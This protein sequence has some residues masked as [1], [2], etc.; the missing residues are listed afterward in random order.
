MNKNFL[1]MNL[2]K[3]NLLKSYLLKK[4]KYLK[5]MRSQYNMYMYEK[6]RIE[7]ILFSTT[8]FHIKLPLIFPELMMMNMNHISSMNVDIEM[9][10]QCGKWRFKYN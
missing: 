8:Y 2:L 5:I 6:Y 3:R 9:I 7:I 4:I 1:K 10:S